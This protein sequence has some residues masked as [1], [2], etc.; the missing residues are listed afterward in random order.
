[1]LSFCLCCVS[2]VAS[3]VYKR[4]S[5]LSVTTEAASAAIQTAA[6]LVKKMRGHSLLLQR[7]AARQQPHALLGAV[8]SGV[9]FTKLTASDAE[10]DTT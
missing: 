8:S 2:F 4:N 1:M 9:P 5:P 10:F 3:Y 7:Y 6:I